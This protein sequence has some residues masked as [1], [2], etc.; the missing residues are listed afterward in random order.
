MANPIKAL[1][2]LTT[3]SKQID[4]MGFGGTAPD[5][6]EVAGALAFPHPFTKKKLK[7]EAEAL[8]R[9]KYCF[10]DSCQKVLV[11]T[12]VNFAKEQG[13]K[14]KEET[15]NNLCRVSVINYKHSLLKFNKETREHER[16][17]LKDSQLSA[18]LNIGRQ[19]FTKKHRELYNKLYD[20]LLQLDL[21]V[22]HHLRGTLSEG[23]VKEAS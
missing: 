22:Q 6:L 12:L 23:E 5:N 11:L 4:G 20:E 1:A 21:M 16:Y 14:F 2:R 13:Y 19:S 3:K 10:D 7:K 8:G 9:F 15:I 17:E 18:L